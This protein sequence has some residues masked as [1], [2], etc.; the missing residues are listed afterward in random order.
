TPTGTITV[1]DGTQSCSASVAAGS[2]TIA[3]SAAGGRIVTATYATDGNF[4]GSTSA[5]V[6][7]TVNPASTTTTITAD[8]P[9]P[10]TVGELYTV[11]YTVAA[12]APGSGTP[13]GTV[14]VTD[15][16]AI[17]TGTVAG[18]SCLLASL[19]PGTKTLTATYA[20]NANSAG[21][22]APSLSQTV[23]PASTTTT[24]AAGTP[25]P[26]GVGQSVSF[27]FSVVPNAPG[28][29]TPTG[30]VT[31]SDGTQNCSASV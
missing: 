24:L 17:C 27:T 21:S 26:S 10:S 8:A 6:S 1:S 12:T 29:G 14:T 16:T 4:A 20:G 31:V 18:G 3:F 30:S 11:N 15:G 22:T 19:T 2:C 9:D 5:G 23:N 7:Q 28:S 13:A 25:N